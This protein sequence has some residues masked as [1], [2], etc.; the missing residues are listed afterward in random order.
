MQIINSDTN[1]HMG[2]ILLPQGVYE[3]P[4]HGDLPLST[5]GGFSNL[6]TVGRGDTVFMYPGGVTVESSPDPFVFLV[7]GLSVV[8]CG[9]G[10][11]GFARKV[12]RWLTFDNFK[13]I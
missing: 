5:S 8:M 13:E 9:A 11:V 6:I 4:V 3:M 2:V 12:G 1:A 7:L 10:M